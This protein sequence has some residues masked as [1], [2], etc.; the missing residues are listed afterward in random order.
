MRIAPRLLA[1]FAAL[2]ALPLNA[3]ISGSVMNSDGKAIAG[4]KI[5]IF[6][7]ETLTSRRERLV[8]KTPQRQALAT[9]TSDANGNF[10]IEPPKDAT[11][12]DMRIDAAGYAPDASR[13]QNDDESGA[14]ILVRAESKTGTVR[15]GGKGVAG[16]TVVW[17]GASEHVATTDENGRYTAPD[18]AKWAGRLL[19]LHPDYARLEESVPQGKRDLDRT[20]NAGV[21]VA[22]KVVAEDGTTAAGD[23]AIFIDG[24]PT[25]K[26]GADGTFTVAHA[27]KDWQEVHAISG[28]RIAARASTGTLTLKLGKGASVTGNIKDMKSQ[29]PVAGAEVMLNTGGRGM[30]GGGFA[31]RSTFTD[32]KGNFTIS[33]LP[34]GSYG[35]NP[36]RPNYTIPN[37]NV[38]VTAGQTQSKPF[39]AT[40]VARVTGVVV[41]EDKKPVAAARVAAQSAGREGMFMMM[42]RPGMGS[43][44]AASGPD[45]RFV[46]RVSQLDSDVQLEAAKKGYPQVKSPI[47][48]LTSGER[49]GNVSLTIPR[50]VAFSGKV[51]D[52]NG[53]PV[54]G[55]SVDAAESQGDMGGPMRRM[56]IAGAA[57]RTEESVTTASDGTFNIRLKEGKYDVV[58]KREGFAAKTLRAQTVAANEKPVEVTLEPGV[59]ISGRVVRN[60]AGV[61][62]VNINGMSEGGMTQA[63][64]GPDGSFTLGDL[65][66]GQMMLNV[67]R[68]DAMIQEMRPVTAP[69]RDL[70]IELPAGGRIT[71][72]VVDKSTRRPITSFQA[73][74]STSRGGGGMTIMMPPM[75]K[76]FTNEDGTFVLENVKPGPTQVMA[77]APG[78]TTGRAPNVEVE[79][80]K[81]VTDIE[82]PLE[83][84]AKL[85]GKVT[86]SNGAPVAGVSVRPEMGGPN[87][88]VMRFDAV[89]TSA[90]TDPNGEYTIESLEPGEK[91]FVFGRS[92]FVT[93]NRTVT[94]ASGKDTKLDVTM[95]SGLRIGGQVVT[96]GGAPVPEATVRASSAAGGGR[97][98]H[99]DAA[100]N[101]QLE[102]LAP[103][104]YTFSASKAGLAT[105]TV[106]DVDI[107]VNNNVRITMKSGA[108]IT[109]RVIGL[110]P[111]EMEQTTVM[112]SSQGG[113]T[114][115]PVDAAGNFRLEG[116]PSGTVRVSARTGAMFGGTG[117]TAVP[118]TVQVDAGGSAQVDIEF[119]SET[120]IRGRVTRNNQ[121]VPNAGVAFMPRQGKAQTN[122]N[123]TADASGRYEISGLEDGPYNVQV[124]D[125]ERMTPF[126]TQYEVRGSGNFD[127]DVRTASLRGRVVDASTGSPLSDANIDVRPKGSDAGF[128]ASRGAMTD[129]NGNFVVEVARGSYQVSA[130]KQGFGHDMKDVNVG[131]SADNVELKLFPSDGV[132]LKVVDARDQRMLNANVR[133]T[134]M[135]GRDMGG[136]PGFRMF[137]GGAEPIRLSLAPGQYRVTVSAMGYAPRTLRIASPSTQNVAMTPGGILLLRSKSS[138]PLRARL[139]DGGGNVYFTSSFNPTGTFRLVESPGT[140]TLQNVAAGQYR[141]DVLDTNDQVLKTI[142]VD[143][144]EGQSMTYD[145]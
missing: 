65:T 91:S 112:A 141:L 134:D 83:A 104:H 27:P 42:G 125:L 24:W 98:A 7:P 76:A 5:S 51:L 10:R 143:V 16:A 50:G 29:L 140:T 85:T 82:V 37:T 137:G 115:A 21:K 86:D 13:Q 99:T 38:S 77:M 133:V 52:K 56:I 9:A 145:V 128:L 12:V 92:G 96:E 106:R 6:A 39:Y 84:G 72:R 62:G 129:S 139:T 43:R 22:G 73:G 69:A 103:G 34:A 49:K 123:T 132:T 19:I 101:F 117:R 107:A 110:A 25:T 109:G 121:P 28:S 111:N 36:N 15:A 40:A 142:T 63:I 138:S 113:G 80:G 23:A 71:G 66:P 35:L 70:V 18:P 114:S 130:E 126:S 124:M 20:L 55:V 53:K 44:A 89:D 93:E 48:R 41:D 90:V 57:G 67:S 17:M 131:D 64:T 97:E 95:G 78:Y 116:A 4:A 144:R 127:I 58:F 45:G 74:V 33:P 26:S 32:A 79:D 2:A 122:A 88:R 30:G 119:K 11:I 135:Q 120:V 31:V 118:K 60:G 68:F 61:E 54:S 1:L 75:L 87:Q 3:A 136:D 8:S 14:V 100:G 102:G 46:L 108:T 105:G 81:T 94:L 47:M 59:E